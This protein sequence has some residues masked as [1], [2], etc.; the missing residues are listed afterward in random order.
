MQVSKSD[1]RGPAQRVTQTSELDLP[2]NQVL[3]VCG[4]P[5]WKPQDRFLESEVIRPV[6]IVAP[7]G[8]EPVGFFDNHRET[9][10]SALKVDAERSALLYAISEHIFRVSLETGEER[11][12]DVPDLFDVHELTLAGDRL[13]VANTGR[14]EIVDLDAVTGAINARHKLADLRAANARPI[15]SAR[16]ETFHANQAFLG[17]RGQLMVLAH[18]A[19]GFRMLSHAQRQLVRHGSGGVIDLESG[20]VRDLRLFGPHNVRRHA[21]GW[22]INNSGRSEVMLLSSDWEVLGHID[23]VGWGTGAAISNDGKTLYSGIRA[24]RRRYAKVGDHSETGVQVVP[25]TS[26]GDGQ[27]L[28][29]PLL[30]QVNGVELVDLATAR[31]IADL[32]PRPSGTSGTTSRS[33]S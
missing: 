22:L 31:K 20:E 33:T 13:L 7:E 25:I 17:D 32:P 4:G 19:H 23:L 28:P 5:N 8:I 9:G 10:V 14:D 18:H 1:G 15:R 27:F 21:E 3:L 29:L 24:T 12:F 30:E 6:E 16:E 11:R 2:D 26:G